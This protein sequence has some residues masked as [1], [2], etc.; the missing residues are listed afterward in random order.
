LIF[1]LNSPIRI[2]FVRYSVNPAAPQARGE[3]LR[4]QHW[5]IDDQSVVTFAAL[6]F[7][8]V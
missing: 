2:G 8:Q 7:R 5:R 4:Y 1:S 3:L 6:G